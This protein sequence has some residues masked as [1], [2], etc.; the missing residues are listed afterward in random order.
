MAAIRYQRVFKE[1]TWW[2]H[3]PGGFPEQ[4]QAMSFVPEE[5]CQRSLG[6]PVRVTCMKA[7]SY[8]A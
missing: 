8:D 4:S 7:H 1:A 6:P 2:G 3:V 5:I